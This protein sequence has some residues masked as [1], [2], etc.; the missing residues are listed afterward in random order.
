M[1]VDYKKIKEIMDTKVVPV[2]SKSVVDLLR[3]LLARDPKERASLCQIH[4]QYKELM[5]DDYELRVCGGK[6]QE[7]P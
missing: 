5:S 2:Y 3:S 4:A 7:R 1:K 6:K